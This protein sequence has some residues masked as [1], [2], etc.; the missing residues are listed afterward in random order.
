METVS[1]DFG[2]CLA[3]R[4]DAWA[5]VLRIGLPPKSKTEL[6]CPSFKLPVGF[7]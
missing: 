3:G 4:G 2:T 1:V 5:L 7:K 6:S